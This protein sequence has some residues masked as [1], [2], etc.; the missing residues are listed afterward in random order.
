MNV[1]TA[2]VATG[3]NTSVV[4]H[5]RQLVASTK[6]RAILE[7]TPPTATPKIRSTLPALLAEAIAEARAAKLAY[8]MAGEN[9]DR[10]LEHTRAIIKSGAPTREEEDAARDS[11]PVPEILKYTPK[12]TESPLVSAT[13]HY[14]NGTQKAVE[15]SVSWLRTSSQIDE[16]FAD[17]CVKAL[18][19]KKALSRHIKVQAQAVRDLADARATPEIIAAKTAKEAALVPWRAARNRLEAAIAALEKAPA[20]PGAEARA[21]FTALLEANDAEVG[22]NGQVRGI[23]DADYPDRLATLMFR[24][25]SKSADQSDK[26]AGKA[27]REAVKAF[28]AARVAERKLSDAHDRLIGKL[29][30]QVPHPPELR[31]RDHVINDAYGLRHEPSLTFEEKAERY[32]ILK[33]FVAARAGTEG[34][35]GVGNAESRAK[36]AFARLWDAYEAMRATPAPSIDALREKVRLQL[37]FECALVD[38][39]VDGVE[40]AARMLLPPTDDLEREERNLFALYKDLLRI[41]GELDHPALAAPLAPSSV[42]EPGAASNEASASA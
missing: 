32:P 10:V 3:D 41:C 22:N 2:T 21:K 20:R 31:M 25:L 12:D 39:M 35:L 14:Q 34:K 6:E 9:R 4:A 11:I 24:Q 29:H 27:W 30:L 33:A 28:E 16:Y 1:H 18:K 8:D 36:A 5:A 40:F 13:F 15:F 37:D 17:D 42:K 38:E 23:E 19:A 26:A 7:G